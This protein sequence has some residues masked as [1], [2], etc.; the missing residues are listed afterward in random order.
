MK[1]REFCAV[2]GLA[3]LGV[4][5]NFV[6][7]KE[8]YD[9]K[10]WIAKEEVHEYKKDE[11]KGWKVRLGRN[12]YHNYQEFEFHFMPLD[13]WQ[14]KHCLL[15]SYDG[16]SFKYAIKLKLMVPYY[17]ELLCVSNITHYS[18]IPEEFRGFVKKVVKRFTPWM[19]ECKT[20][21]EIRV[22]LTDELSE[23]MKNVQL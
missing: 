21:S 10:I 3:G 7:A 12:P 9:D 4:T 11:E 8:E 1:R 17:T 2:A 13:H 5:P 18:E 19:K 23:A 16:M 22:N 15:V 20:K 14:H 6:S